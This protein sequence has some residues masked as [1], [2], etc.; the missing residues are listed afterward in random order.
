[1]FAAGAGGAIGGGAGAMSSFAFKR[2]LTSQPVRSV[3]DQGVWNY[4]NA[5]NVIRPSPL[6]LFVMPPTGSK[7]F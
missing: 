3:V 4:G 6:R 2:A 1:M 7:S 5:P